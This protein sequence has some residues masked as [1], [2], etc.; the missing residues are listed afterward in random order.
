MR[1][2]A[3]ATAAVVLFFCAVAL[4]EIFLSP[5]LTCRWNAVTT[6]VDGTPCGISAYELGISPTGVDLNSNSPIKSI[7]Y[8]GDQ[9]YTGLGTD[10]L[11]SGLA[12]GRYQLQ[13]RAKTGVWGAWSVPLQVTIDLAPPSPPTGIR[14]Q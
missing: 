9:G 7:V 12:S 5:G 8:P 10:S 13:A 2:S 4:G 14:G 1:R 6:H 3:T 11:L